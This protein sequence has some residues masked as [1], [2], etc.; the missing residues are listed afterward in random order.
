MNPF[1]LPSDKF[2]RYQHLSQLVKLLSH[3]IQDVSIL[4]LGA[5]EDFLRIFLPEYKTYQM[6]I[7]ILKKHDNIVRGDAQFIPFRDGSFDFVCAL[8]LLEHT[9]EWSRSKIISEVARIAKN[10]SF[11]SFPVLSDRNVRNEAILNQIENSIRG[12]TGTFL[13]EHAEF[14]LVNEAYITDEL[15]QYYPY[16]CSYPNF[17]FHS[18]FVISLIES[19]FSILPD[20]DQFLSNLRVLLNQA[21]YEKNLVS[22]PFYRVLTVGSQLPLPSDIPPVQFPPTDEI[23][24]NLAVNIKKGFDALKSLN[25]YAV[26]LET[27]NVELQKANA[28]NQK[29][30]VQLTTELTQQKQAYNEVSEYAQKLKLNYSQCQQFTTDLENR[31][32]ILEKQYTLLLKASRIRNTNSNTEDK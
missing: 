24:E 26:K 6:D 4:D 12:Q 10:S 32:S 28:R 3:S 2:Q 16:V 27:D 8:D 25:D 29:V 14:G 31:L 15:E 9:P 20:L 7:Q 11:F 22:A 21:F 23:L 17:N 13:S 30:L 18:W 19:V 5:N 1:E